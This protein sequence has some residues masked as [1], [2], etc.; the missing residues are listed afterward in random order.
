MKALVH[1]AVL[2]ETPIRHED[3]LG[4]RPRGDDSMVRQMD[5]PLPPLSP[6][7]D[8]E[9]A[10]ARAALERMRRRREALLAAREGELFPEAAQEIA[11]MRAERDA[12]LP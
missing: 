4:S 12:R 11:E 9:R 2:A 6:P 10:R 8:E 1:S 3:G 5:I 7:T